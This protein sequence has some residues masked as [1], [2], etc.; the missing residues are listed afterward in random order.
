MAVQRPRGDE[1]V[2]AVIAWPRKDE[3]GPPR[4]PDGDMFGCQAAGPLHQIEGGAET[5]CIF[6]LGAPN[7]SRAENDG[8]FSHAGYRRACGAT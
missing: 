6:L 2:T 4:R 7:F 1:A 3:N 5:L 8:T